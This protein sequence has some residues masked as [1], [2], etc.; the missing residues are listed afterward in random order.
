LETHFLTASGVTVPAEV[1]A[2]YFPWDTKPSIQINIRDVTE[3]RRLENQLLQMQ[4]MQSI[5]RLASGIAHDLNN[6]LTAILVAGHL[7][8]TKSKDDAI[9]GFLDT[10][11]RSAG[12][13]AGIIK[14]IL[15]FARGVEGDR[16]ALRLKAEVK[17]MEEILA[18]TFP[19]NIEIKTELPEEDWLVLGDSTQL[20][21]VLMNLCVN[22]R[23][24]M[25]LGGP[26]MIVLENLTLDAA[27]AA[28]LHGEAK[29]GP[30]VKLSVV[31]TG[32]GIRPE[33]LEKLFEP[34]VTTKEPGKAA[35]L[36]L[37]SAL[38]IVKSHGGFITVETE[39]GK[40]SHF[41]VYLP[42]IHQPGLAEKPKPVEELPRG[43]GEMILVV[44]DQAELRQM[45]E[46]SL[47]EYDYRV[48]IAKEGPEAVALFSRHQSEVSLVIVDYQMPVLDGVGTMRALQYLNPQARMVLMTGL[49]ERDQVAAAVKQAR[50]TLLLKPFTVETLLKTVR[51][52]LS[53]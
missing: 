18:Q 27:M 35:G 43:R 22:A 29:P 20:H 39:V 3:K 13:S 44:D 21:Q 50:A 30:Y 51:H 5:G 46:E 26:L 53:E 28:G 12:H 8:R 25:P 9:A 36:G 19:P 42:A 45:L 52:A 2:G 37:S 16:K 34:F 11:Q 6:S 17:E 33:V 38:G 49:G 1:T 7:A 48:C 15:T 40:G 4:R 14:Q 24:S 31:D 41:N 10:I 32:T 47:K 23:D